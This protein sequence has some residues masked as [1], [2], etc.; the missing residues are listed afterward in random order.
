M[1]R[2]LEWI[3]LKKMLHEKMKEPP[4]VFEG[5]IWWASIGENIGFEINGKSQFFSRPVIIFKKLSRQFYLVIPTTSQEKK[6]SWFVSMI[7]TLIIKTA[8]L[9]Q[10]RVMDY[11]RLHSRLGQLH[12]SDFKNIKNG[13]SNLYT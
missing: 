5:D 10:I 4:H 12:E 3:R 2:F 1:K 8:C 9:H 7:S 13:F 6:G 11:R